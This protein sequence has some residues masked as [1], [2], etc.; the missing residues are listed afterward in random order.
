MSIQL[1]GVIKGKYI[2]LEH[3]T[4]LPSGSNV[5][6]QIQAKPLSLEEKQQI[7]DTLSGVWQ[8]D[9]SLLPI[10][11]EIEQQRDRTT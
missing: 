4:G 6:V 7:V 5:V 9:R 3:D 8:T 11:E 1:Q 10:F 2:E